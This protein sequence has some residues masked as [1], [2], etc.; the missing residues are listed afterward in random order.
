MFS[1]INYNYKGNLLSLTFKSANRNSLNG[2]FNIVQHSLGAVNPDAF[3]PGSDDELV[4]ATLFEL[5]KMTYT[6]RTQ[7]IGKEIELFLPGKLEFSIN[8]S[9]GKIDLSLFYAKLMGELAIRYKCDVLEDGRE[10]VDGF[11]QD[12]NRQ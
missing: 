4:D 3:D 8:R 12:Y 1:G 10:K 9:I 2:D 6:N 5:S 11:F 7:Y